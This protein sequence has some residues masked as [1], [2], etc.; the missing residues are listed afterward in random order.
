[1][2]DQVTL[3]VKNLWVRRSNKITL[4][5]VSFKAKSCE[6][7]GIIGP[8]G[9][10]K[11]TL[12]SAICG[13]RPFRGDVVLQEGDGNPEESL[14]AEGAT[15]YW[16][17]RIGYVP[18]DDVLHKNLSIR[19]ALFYVGKLRR[20]DL[21]KR[22]LYEQ[23]EKLL[24]EFKIP[25]DARTR[26]L[27]TLSS[28]QRKKVNICAELLNNPPILLL[29]EPTSNLDPNAEDELMELLRKRANEQCQTIIVITHTLN[30][31]RYCDR[32]IFLEN[33]HIA[34]GGVGWPNLVQDN[35]WRQARDI[36]P[37]IPDETDVFKRWVYIFNEFASRTDKQQDIVEAAQQ[38]WSKRAPALTLPPSSRTPP[39]PRWWAQLRILFQRYIRIQ[40]A[41]GLATSLKLMLGLIG[42]FLLLVLHPNS[43]VPVDKGNIDLTNARNGVFYV[44]FIVMILGLLA[45]FQEIT[46]EWWIYQHERRKGLSIWAYIFSKWLPLMLLG[47]LVPLQ[48]VAVL[49]LF[50]KQPLYQML[51]DK[52]GLT[53]QGV[54]PAANPGWLQTLTKDLPPIV[55]ETAT[56]FNFEGLITLM[57]ACFASLALGLAISALAWKS[58]QFATALLGAIIIFQVLMSGLSVNEA[59]RQVTNFLEIFAVNHWAIRGY[60]IDLAIYCWNW[61]DN[62]KDY[63]SPGMLLGVWL[64]LGVYMLVCLGLCY[65]LLR[66]RDPWTPARRT[67]KHLVSSRAT[68]AAFLVVATLIGS[69]LVLRQSSREYHNLYMSLAANGYVRAVDTQSFAGLR[70]PAR[71]LAALSVAQCY[72]NHPDR[73]QAALPR[74]SDDLGVS[75]SAVVSPTTIPLLPTTEVPDAT[76]TLE[77]PG[78]MPF[79]ATSAP[80]AEPT[81]IPAPVLVDYPNGVAVVSTEL[82]YGPD[83]SVLTPLPQQTPLLMLDRARERPWIRVL[84]LPQAG[85]TTPPYIGWVHVAET[86]F[87]LSQANENVAVPQPCARP[88]TYLHKGQLSWTSTRA[89]DAIIL[90]DV[91]RDDVGQLVQGLTLRLLLNDQEIDAQSVNTRGRFLIYQRKTLFS[92][93]PNDVLR[94]ELDGSRSDIDIF[95]VIF[96]V[97]TGCSL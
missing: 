68:L 81:P 39:R 4:V 2:P 90:I 23:I 25:E 5:D 8:N 82:R 18:V 12:I 63:Y 30:T 19:K 72:D 89:S 77:N 62:F 78:G 36:N 24:D 64:A 1:M 87:D 83:L 31:L 29:D 75:P 93:K 45:S 52:P 9:A 26:I 47:I 27:D 38:E 86:S 51:E 7:T 94:L 57:L 41:N 46:S 49:V 92:V 33:G 32:I 53:V 13:E 50:H 16:L 55:A 91:F 34:K 48:V 88:E 84:A 96:L 85:T 11:S 79:N 97:E 6:L 66:L 35:L 22:D 80:D 17:P 71:G 14:Y 42:G 37:T 74:L 15:E 20:P 76:P 21:R 69:I 60:S 40:Y 10:G 54:F 73:L 56:L 43:F 28:G 3:Q 44:S 70:G 59:W 67:L 95:A 65:M 61:R 58:N